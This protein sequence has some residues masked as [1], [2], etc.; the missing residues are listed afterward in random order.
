MSQEGRSSC[1]SLGREACIEEWRG[2]RVE[3]GLERVR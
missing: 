2:A 1:S 3:K